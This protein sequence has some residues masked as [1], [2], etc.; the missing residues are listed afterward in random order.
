MEKTGDEIARQEIMKAALG[1]KL[2]SKALFEDYKEVISKL[3]NVDSDTIEKRIN[4]RIEKARVSYK[5]K[6]ADLGLIVD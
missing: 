2:L 1:A 3:T 6:L 5:S 4:E